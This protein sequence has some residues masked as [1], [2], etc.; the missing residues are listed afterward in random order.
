MKIGLCTTDLVPLPA[1]ALFERLANY[2][3][4]VTQMS[5]AS[6]IEAGYEPDGSLEI[7]PAVASSLLRDISRVSSR[8]GVKIA[9]INGTFNMAHRD[10]AVRTEGLRRFALLVQAADALNCRMITLCSG[11]RNTQSLWAPHPDNDLQEAWDDMF[12]CVVR[13]AD[14]AQKYGIMLAVETEAANIID[15]PEKARRLMDDAGCET[16]K[17][18]MDGA[19]LFH[20][21]QA[22]RENVQAVLTHAFS[23]FGRDVVIAHGKDIRES[24]GIDFC[25]T[26]EGILDF[27]LFARLL[28]DNGYQGDMFLHGIYEEQKIPAAIAF[29]RDAA[30]L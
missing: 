7:P 28:K 4:T 30:G 1:D 13:C 26:G 19:N 3:T 16:V 10:N 8:H 23:V 24:E 25:G 2:G 20:P 17:M 5:F 29:M 27:P 14:I 22:K 11:T 21:G 18:I 6:I 12:D 9:A 15:T